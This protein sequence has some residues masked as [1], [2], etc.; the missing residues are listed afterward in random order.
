MFS[1]KYSRKPGFVGR[2]ETFIGVAVLVVLAA[3]GAAIYLYGSKGGPQKAVEQITG[4]D[5]DVSLGGPMIPLAFEGIQVGAIQQQTASTSSGPQASE[6]LGSLAVPE[7]WVAGEVE[8][9]NAENLYEKINGRAEAY[10]SYGFQSLQ[11]LSLTK[12][13]DENEFID[14]FVFDH[15]S[16]LNAFGIYASERPPDPTLV[17]LGREGYDSSGSLFFWK[18]TKYVQVIP[19]SENEPTK[20]VAMEMTRGVETSI[21]DDGSLLEGLDLLPEAGRV[22][23]TEQFILKNALSQEFLDDTYTAMYDAGDGGRLRTFVTK[24]SSTAEASSLI[25]QYA[26]YLAKYAKPL[27]LKLE[28]VETASGD[29]AG[30]FELV[31]TEGDFFAGVTEAPSA[32]AATSG[33][34]ALREHLKTKTTP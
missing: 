7:G 18:G 31:F 11:T 24:R 5:K 23:Q 2:K 29:L 19:S 28:G 25:K 12:S 4:L 9:F 33:A 26:Q 13:D 14:I 34:Q 16:P 22:A 21:A 15:G 27:D 3:T 20:A 32:K 10:I 6:G 1:R 8:D 17:Q 30:T